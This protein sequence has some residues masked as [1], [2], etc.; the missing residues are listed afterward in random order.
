[1][2]PVGVWLWGVGGAVGSG[3]NQLRAP[4]WERGGARTGCGYGGWEELGDQ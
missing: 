3:R 4:L 1:M 2:K